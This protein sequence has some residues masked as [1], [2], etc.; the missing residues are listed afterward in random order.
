MREH[1]ALIQKLHLKSVLGIEKRGIG[2]NKMKKIISV[3]LEEIDGV[4]YE[5][6]ILEQKK[7]KKWWQFYK[8]DTFC[9][10]MRIKY[11]RPIR[12]SLK[13]LREC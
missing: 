4:L 1:L 3:D 6:T 5:I 13:I 8:K 7:N 10:S 12:P 11:I 2:E 9:I